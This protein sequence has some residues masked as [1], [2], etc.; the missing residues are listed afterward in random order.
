[1]KLSTTGLN[2]L[3]NQMLLNTEYRK[4][5]LF[6]F[7]GIFSNTANILCFWLLHNNF[8]L[9]S[10]LS[11]TCSYFTGLYVGY[12]LNSNYTFRINQKFKYSFLTYLLI[13]IFIYFVYLVYNILVISEFKNFSL[14]LHIVGVGFCAVLNF[15]ILNYVWGK[16][17]NS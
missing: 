11:G 8:N 16:H 14:L 3:K 1:M 5:R 4:L 7:S 12:F 13:Q 15:I 10:S 9:S 6:V 17:G 2:I